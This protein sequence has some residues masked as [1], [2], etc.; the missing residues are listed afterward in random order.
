ML[1]K[2]K[3]L[4]AKQ[5]PTMYCTCATCPDPHTHSERKRAQSQVVTLQGEKESLTSKVGELEG[6]VKKLRRELDE[7]TE[8][9]TEVD[10]TQYLLA[11]HVQCGTPVHLTGHACCNSGLPRSK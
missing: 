7:E 2:S 11:G 4:V 3:G 1:F 6:E 10:H 9:A 8:K 5:H